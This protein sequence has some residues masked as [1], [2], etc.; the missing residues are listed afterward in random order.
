M[1][2]HVTSSKSKEPFNHYDSLSRP[3]G[4]LRGGKSRGFQIIEKLPV[5]LGSPV[6]DDTTRKTPGPDD[7]QFSRLLSLSGAFGGSCFLMSQSSCQACQ[8]AWL[9]CGVNCCSALHKVCD[10][11]CQP[12]LL[13]M[14]N[15]SML[16]A[17]F[18][19]FFPCLCFACVLVCCAHFHPT[20]YLQV[21]YII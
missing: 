5:T 9:Q 6:S 2:I 13:L 18:S 17:G 16:V 15:V 1:R 14:R 11:I 19:F 20:D 21:K 4:W 7:P 12:T 8:T 3:R 10:L